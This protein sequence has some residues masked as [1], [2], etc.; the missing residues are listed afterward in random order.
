MGDKKTLRDYITGIPKG[1]KTAI[2]AGALF[3]LVSATPLPAQNKVYE[4]GFTPYISSPHTELGVQ[5]DKKLEI[6]EFVPNEIFSGWSISEKPS[7]GLEFNQTLFGFLGLDVGGVYE[8]L[9]AYMGNKDLL[10]LDVNTHRAYANLRL[11]HKFGNVTPFIAGGINY[12]FWD[13]RAN[14]GDKALQLVKDI[15]TEMGETIPPDFPTSVNPYLTVDP[16]LGW[17]A[18]AGV[19]AKMTKHMSLMAR[20]GYLSM[21]SGQIEKL[22]LEMNGEPQGE[23]NLK[24]QDIDI[25]L[26]R[27][28]PVAE[29]GVSFNF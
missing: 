8:P 3:G 21:T 14:V 11:Q 28:G 16:G 24:E 7:I 2:A 26:N 5:L 13:V 17:Q 18:F 1:I 29:L 10:S 22:V 9:K 12:S 15:M 20:V 6:P 27:Q 19:K 4:F 25:R 23:L